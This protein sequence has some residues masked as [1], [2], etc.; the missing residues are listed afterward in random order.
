MIYKYRVK[1][2][3]LK[4]TLSDRLNSKGIKQIQ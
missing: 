4:L 3:D 2:L 1:Y